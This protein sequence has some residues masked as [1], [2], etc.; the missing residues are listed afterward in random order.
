MIEISKSPTADTRTCDFTKV[1]KEQ[2]L[3]ASK[4]HIHDVRLGMAFFI[5]EIYTALE[6]HDFDK[7]GDIEGFH[8]D[9]LTGFKQTIWWDKHRKLNRHHLNMEDGVPDD[10][11]LVDVLDFIVDCVMSGMARSGS[12]YPLQLPAGLLERAFQNSVKLLIQQVKV[13]E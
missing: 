1:S 2:L 4:Q 8:E 6:R 3:T 10:V 13:K 11:N 9:F 7:I 5:S 12:V